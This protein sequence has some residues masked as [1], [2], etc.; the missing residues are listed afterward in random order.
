MGR[1]LLTMNANPTVNRQLDDQAMDNIDH[2]LGRPVSPL[3][4]TSRNYFA[5]DDMNE[6]AAMA[7]STHWA[8]AGARGDMTYFRVTD[9]G[10]QALADHLATLQRQHR[11]YLVTFDDYQTV[12]P[13]ESRGQ[14]RYK[15]WL[16]V[17]DCCDI[18]FAE[19]QRRCRVR[20]AA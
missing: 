1:G 5:T 2:A 8:C 13:A 16:H 18:S 7:Y 15:Y 6:I 17:S 14:A 4:A 20:L 12:I 10:R 19:L 9:A 3:R 11:P